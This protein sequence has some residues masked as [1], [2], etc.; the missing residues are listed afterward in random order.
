MACEGNFEAATEAGA[1]DGSDFGF[2]WGVGGGVR[3]GGGGGVEAG[4]LFCFVCC[5]W[6]FVLFCVLQPGACLRPAD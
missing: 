2:A 5:R 1:V 6:V 3:G 4:C